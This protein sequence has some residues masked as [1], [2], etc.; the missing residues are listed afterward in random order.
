MDRFISEYLERVRPAFSAI[1]EA[2]GHQLAF[3][4]LSY[5][6]GIYHDAVTRCDH[7]LKLIEGRPVPGVIGIALRIVRERAAA[8]DRSRY[9]A[10]LPFLFTKPD[11]PF[12]IIDPSAPVVD[13]DLFQL[14]NALII[15]Y[16]A[17]LSSSPDD[18]QAL[19][20]QE[21][22]VLQ[23]LATYKKSLKV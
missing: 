2:A 14:T 4:F 18:E 17:A 3:A 11:L 22:Y 20:E 23:L 21:K 8:L 9:D 5:K 15:L 6:L 19:E 13:P 12:G 10:K 1:P 16:A 7:A